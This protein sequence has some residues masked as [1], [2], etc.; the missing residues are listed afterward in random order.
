MPI[1][2]PNW[3]NLMPMYSQRRVSD[4]MSYTSKMLVIGIV[5][6]TAAMVAAF[7]MTTA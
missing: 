6:F 5:L 4:R 1:T 2:Y 3:I 7:S